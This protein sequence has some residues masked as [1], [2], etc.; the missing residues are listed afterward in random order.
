M[1]EVL[2]P[3]LLEIYESQYARDLDGRLI[4]VEQ[5]TQK[6]LTKILTIT[7]DGK[8]VKIP[9]AVPKT[10]D[11]GNLLRDA[12]RRLVPRNVTIFD[13]ANALY[14]VAPTAENPVPENTNP[15]PVLCHQH[16]VDPV[17]VCRVCSVL[18]SRKGKAAPRLVPACQHFVTDGM[19]IHTTESRQEVLFPG[20]EKPSFAGDYVKR[21][22]KVLVELL[23]A[24][25]LYK[26]QPKDNQKYHNEILALTKRFD[27]PVASVPATTELK[28]LKNSELNEFMRSECNDLVPQTPFTRK[29]YDVTRRDD[30]SLVISYDANQC[31]LC[32]R[33]VRA[34]SSV[35]PFEIIGHTG[36]GYTARV[37]FD[38]GQPMAE[39]GCVSC[40][41]CAVSC[42]TGA[43]TFKRTINE[44]AVKLG[45][46]PN[47]WKD[48]APLKPVTV[49]AE[50][51][52]E[53][54]LFKGVPYAF[55]KWNEGSVGRLKCQPKQVEEVLCRAGDYGST[56]FVIEDGEIDVVVGPGNKVVAT[57]T[58]ADIIVG[59][60]ACMTHQPRLAKLRVPPGGE[61]EILVLRRNMLH[62][63]QRNQVGRMILYPT[64]RRRAIDNYLKKGQL[65]AGLTAEQNQRC[66]DFLRSRQLGADHYALAKGTEEGAPAAIQR[67]MNESVEYLQVD[68]GQVIIRQGDPADSF[69]IVNLGFVT[70]TRKTHSDRD[71]VLDY[72]GPGRHFGE[73]GLLSSIFEDVANKLPESERGLRT[74]TCTA[75]D[76][77]EVIR[78]GVNAFRSLFNKEPEIGESLRQT[79]LELL[80]KDRK[81]GVD[82]PEYSLEKFVDAGL[83]EG[84][85]LLVIDL[86][87]C[88]RCQECVQACADSHQQVGRLILEGNR[89]G[90][91]LI[92]SA[93]RSCHDPTCLVGCPVDAIH[94]V[95][96]DRPG[97]KSL[98]IRIENHCIGCGLCATNCAFG[99]IHMQKPALD[100]QQ[101]VK[102]VAT[103]C[104]L[105]E[106]IDGVPRCVYHCPHDAAMRMDGYDFGLSVGLRP[107]GAARSGHP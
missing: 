106:S 71:L 34:C 61:A 70:V 93:C 45:A 81:A 4:Q 62:M 80:S 58:P 86:Q 33:C 105:C 6:D 52:R 64:Y 55:L 107:L 16:H 59:E 85:N 60:M 32:D 54:R 36:F 50:E 27:V 40:G 28:Q 42:P 41:E 14:M 88:T 10:D 101:Y 25:Y 73:I 66:V 67:D 35:K 1:A 31:I 26:D 9:K 19:E 96:A 65:F 49:K 98:A 76:H 95:P 57:V 90:S 94:R 2:T 72:M 18:T 104:D 83:F 24:N 77:V 74:A 69:Y 78:I 63:L 48:L 29:Q 17:G 13:A 44:T 102:R 3:E 43:L 5:A 8:E 97:E 92:P 103:N 47:P 56:A 11:Q 20:D 51:L 39:S 87:K 75:R 15:I 23:A 12:E 21:N 30:S 46:D 89:Y 68:P 53:L 84:Q 22:V 79:C 38:L 100:K 82:V 7:I 91:Y 37:S 99:S